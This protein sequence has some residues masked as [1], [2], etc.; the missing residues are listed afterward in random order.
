M[1]KHKKIVQELEEELDY[2]FDNIKIKDLDKIE[3]LLETNIYVYSCNE[4][5]LN[6]ITVYKSNKNY[7]KYLDL[8]L[9]NNHFMS[10]KKLVNSFIQKLIIRHG[11]VEIVA[12][13]FIQK[14][15]IMNIDYFVK[16]VKQ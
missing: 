10:I 12:I 4:K 13:Y 11:F 2:N 9:F 14:K 6:R 16:R 1:K 8:L 5:M 3:K 7:E 15:S